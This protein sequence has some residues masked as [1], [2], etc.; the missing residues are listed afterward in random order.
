M[1]HPAWSSQIIAATGSLQNPAAIRAVVVKNKKKTSNTN[2]NAMLAWGRNKSDAEGFGA[3][4]NR[5]LSDP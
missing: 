3:N 4:L 5:R 2:I 1:A